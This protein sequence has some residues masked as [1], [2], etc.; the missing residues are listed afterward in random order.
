M[1]GLELV[2]AVAAAAQILSSVGALIQMSFELRRRIRHGPRTIQGFANHLDAL[3]SVLDFIR[4]RTSLQ[5]EGIQ[6]YICGLHERVGVI[7]TT[8]KKRLG[9]FKGSICRRTLIAIFEVKAEREVIR[10]FEALDRD[11]SNLLL[12][13]AATTHENVHR[14]AVMTS[15]EVQP[16]AISER[17]PAVDPRGAR[18]QP[19][20]METTDVSESF[21]EME[22]TTT[23]ND[24]G[25]HA[26]LAR[27]S[28]SSQQSSQQP[29]SR[30]RRISR[31]ISRSSRSDQAPTS[32]GSPS[33]P[34][35]GAAYQVKNV[36]NNQFGGQTR[37]VG[38][39]DC[40]LN[41]TP[42]QETLVKLSQG[43]I[44]NGGKNMFKKKT[45]YIGG[46]NV[47]LK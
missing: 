39:S 15:R 36:G 25:S 41:G 12:F 11:K 43:R 37:Y 40:K 13:I 20:A 3:I 34:D 31:R 17:S 32:E 35:D 5:Q 24:T 4:S 30:F 10:S 29:V 16:S 21:E 18:L 23:S 33:P 26:Q 44:Y 46:N 2:G 45:T 19:Q 27:L 7:D 42:G 6:T 22:I 38:G 28:S 47:V 1:S 9:Y 8:L 14:V